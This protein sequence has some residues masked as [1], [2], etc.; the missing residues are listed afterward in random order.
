MV[1]IREDLKTVFS[2]YKSIDDFLNINNNIVRDFKNRKTGR[3]E[4]SGKGFYIKKHFECGMGTLIDELLNLRKP[5]IGAVHERIALDKLSE[6]GIDTM[7]VAAFGTD[8][9]TLSSQRSF[10]VTD[11]ITNV[12][13]L[14]DFCQPWPT[15]PPPI[16]LKN[17]L[18]RKVASIAKEQHK[19]GINHRDFYICHFLLDIAT[20]DQLHH[21]KTPRI[22]LIDL[23]RAQI[24]NKVPFRWRVK[25]IGAL[26]YSALNIGL[27]PRDL[28]RFIRCYTGEPAKK[29]LVRDKAFWH[30]VQ[31]R[32]VKI[33]QRDFKSTPTLV[34][35]SK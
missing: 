13:S 7:K 35:K 2:Q 29:S 5:H 12:I 33:Y 25:D 21:E 24:R 27:T 20:I 34:L 8:G 14:E 15:T 10:I 19:N 23:H 31:N 17:G 30:A 6:L 9:N 32:A 16:D 11:E 22:Y 4:L 1:Y 3:F 18:I 26:Y 28:I